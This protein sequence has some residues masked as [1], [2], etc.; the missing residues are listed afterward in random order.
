MLTLAVLLALLPSAPPDTVELRPGL[1]ITRSVVVR[2]VTR[3]EAVLDYTWG[4]R[5]LPG[6]PA[7]RFGVTAEGV[8]DL[9]AGEY[10]LATI[11]DDGIRVWVDDA[12]VVDRWSGHESELA[13]VP[14]APG[15]RRLRVEYYQVDGWVELRVEVRKRER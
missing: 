9:P 14:I 5:P 12:L 6:F 7:A 15:R 10:E 2:L 4:R 3:T 8:V 11:S 13:I 1:V